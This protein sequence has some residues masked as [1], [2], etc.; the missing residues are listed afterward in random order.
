MPLKSL[1]ILTLIEEMAEEINN[2][3][4][5]SLHVPAEYQKFVANV[6]P[7]EHSN[8]IAPDSVPFDI[9]L[10][11][12]K[13]TEPGI[14][15]FVVTAI[16]DSLSYGEHKITINVPATIVEGAPV[17]EST[18]GKV[19]GGGFLREH[20][21]SMYNFGFN[22]HYNSKGKATMKGQLQFSDRNGNKS[23]HGNEVLSLV[24]EE[25]KAVF[26]GAGL[27]NGKEGF[28][29]KVE[30][31]DNGNPG[32]GNDTFFIEITN[33]DTGS[34]MYATGGI[35]DGGNIKVHEI[36][37]KIK[38]EKKTTKKGKGKKK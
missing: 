21:T 22:V 23:F 14:Y 20:D 9:E 26:T 17:K 5:L 1:V 35:I 15:E 30:V 8:L 33:D 16:G 24:V 38:K 12:P 19:T 10:T 37:P 3:T 28:S 6:A 18:F 34:S 27:L 13:G 31:V 7:N 2:V 25:N 4:N 36:K 11:V 32:R 29:Y